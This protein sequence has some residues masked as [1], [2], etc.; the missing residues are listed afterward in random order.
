MGGILQK[1][2][3]NGFALA[4]TV[5][6]SVFVMAIF[7]MI[8]TNF[9]PLMGE[10]E[11][12]ETYDDVDSKYA[13]YWI[14]RLIQSDDF[15]FSTTTK[16]NINGSTAYQKIT[17]NNT[18]FKGDKINLCNQLY[19][20]FGVKNVYLITYNTQKFRTKVTSN[21][22]SFSAGL[23]EYVLY[24]PNY[25]SPSLNNA[26]YRIIVEYQR[27]KDDNDYYAYSTIEVKRE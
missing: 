27:T 23:E 22:S 11:R 10:Y 17:C 3:R 2:K 19:Q 15:I 13:S 7:S 1:Q 20:S 12:R 4:E 5:V 24:L 6:V 21:P 14:K 16:N 18:Y 26:K 25:S 9:Y 8:Y